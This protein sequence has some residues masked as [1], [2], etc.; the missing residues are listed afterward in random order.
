LCFF[1]ANF[2]CVIHVV[3]DGIVDCSTRGIGAERVDVL[4]LGDVDGLQESLAEISQGGRGPGLDV[5]RGDLGEE[6]TEGSV[7]V[8]GGE[9]AT[10][11]EVLDVAARV[12]GGAGFGFFTG[13]EAAETGMA[14]RERGSAT[15]IGHHFKI[16]QFELRRRAGGIV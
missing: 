13:M 4:I 14:G 15:A 7:E 16:I 3:G 12:F 5:A 11:E 9:I 6:A 10:G 1:I 8:T 2:L